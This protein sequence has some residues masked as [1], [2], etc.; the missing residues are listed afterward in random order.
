[1]TVVRPAIIYCLN[2]AGNYYIKYSISLLDKELNDKVHFRKCIAGVTY[3]LSL[4]TLAALRR[5]L[6][7]IAA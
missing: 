7:S 6:S 2:K 1:M 5:R 4:T 3:S